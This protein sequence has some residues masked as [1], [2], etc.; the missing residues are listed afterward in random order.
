MRS[1]RRTSGVG[2][3]ACVLALA[4]LPARGEKQDH[5]YQVTDPS[6]VYLGSGKH[7]KSPAVI[8]ADKV[9]AEIP[10]YKTILEEG[11]TDEDPRYHLLMKRATKRFE[12]A[13][14][15]EAKRESYD[16]IAEVG[17]VKALKKGKKIPSATAGLIELVSRD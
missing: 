10:E 1:T 16:L 9:W 5:D 14:V 2:I 12:D 6:A 8:S 13:L 3:V 4:V 15:K 11:L 7:P 17:A